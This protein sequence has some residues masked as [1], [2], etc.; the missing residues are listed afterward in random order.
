MTRH[1]DGSVTLTE[2]EYEDM[3]EDV[4]WLRCLEYAG[5]DDWEGIEAAQDILR[6]ME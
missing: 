6:D 2:D 1:E 3:E 5:V 4:K